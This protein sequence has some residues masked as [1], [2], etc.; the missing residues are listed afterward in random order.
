MSYFHKVRPLFAAVAAF[1]LWTTPVAHAQ[2]CGGPPAH[3]DVSSDF[4]RHWVL[5]TC[6]QM[7]LSTGA[8]IPLDGIPVTFSLDSEDLTC[9]DSSETVEEHRRYIMR[10][11]STRES[12]LIAECGYRLCHM[13]NAHASSAVM[14]IFTHMCG[15]GFADTSG[16]SP[17][18]SIS[19]ADPHQAIVWSETTAGTMVNIDVPVRNHNPGVDLRYRAG[20][21]SPGRSGRLMSARSGT[22]NANAVTNVTIRMRIPSRRPLR[23]EPVYIPY[24][25]EVRAGGGV[26]AAHVSGTVMVYAS[27]DED[28]YA[29]CTDWSH[30]MCVRCEVP[31]SASVTSGSCGG[32]PEGDA[33][34]S[35]SGRALARGLPEDHDTWIAVDLDS[36]SAFDAWCN[37]NPGG[38][39]R[40]VGCVGPFSG[41][42]GVRQVSMAIPHVSVPASGLLEATT[43]FSMC[44]AAPG[45]CD[46]VGTLTFRSLVTDFEDD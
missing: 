22:L 35:F 34:V 15:M 20:R 33:S 46:L 28:R 3:I 5:Y 31:L 6:S 24:R 36:G 38:H 4:I 7:N 29:Y 26:R 2:D 17:S 42:R 21:V 25:V 16:S 9:T 10:Y 11:L 27:T 43:G 1:W 39:H 19:V 32:M 30:D 44:V 18:A 14:E 37:G 45:G 12:L 41:N 13:R 8:T 40:G 23:G